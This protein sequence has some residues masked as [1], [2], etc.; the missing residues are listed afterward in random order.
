M[1]Y[2]YIIIYTI[3]YTPAVYHPGGKY[4]KI[5]KNDHRG[6]LVTMCLTPYT[7]PRPPRYTTRV[8]I[9]PKSQK[10]ITGGGVLYMSYTV[11]IVH[12]RRLAETR[13]EQESLLT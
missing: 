1:I 12:L 3:Y 8:V 6:C 7:I 5:P 13:D 11:L 2:I 10:A 9:I 4:S